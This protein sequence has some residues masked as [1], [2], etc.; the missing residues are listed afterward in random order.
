MQEGDKQCPYALPC[1]LVLG[2]KYDYFRQQTEF[3]YFNHV[4]IPA[5]TNSRTQTNTIFFIL[6]KWSAFLAHF[7]IFSENSSVSIGSSILLETGLSTWVIGV[8]EY[9]GIIINT[10]KIPC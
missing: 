6:L 7:L 4:N 10:V 2:A 8:I 3:V 5:V 9:C 1:F